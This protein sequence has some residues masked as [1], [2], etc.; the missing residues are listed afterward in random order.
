M[1]AEV[2]VVV[3]SPPARGCAREVPVVEEVVV[4][5][6]R[7][8]RVEREVE[9]VEAASTGRWRRWWRGRVTSGSRLRE[10]GGGGG[11]GDEG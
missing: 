1:C 8:G 4:G 2:M 11:G 5:P 7:E 3:M 9:E 10:G 6:R